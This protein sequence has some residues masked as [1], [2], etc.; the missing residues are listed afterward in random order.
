MNQESPVGVGMSPAAR[1]SRTPVLIALV[2]IVSSLLSA[3]AIN[4]VPAIRAFAF[5][6][7]AWVQAGWALYFFLMPLG[8][9]LVMVGLVGTAACFTAKYSKFHRAIAWSMAG[10]MLLI[11]VVGC[12]GLFLMS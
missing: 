1:S 6:E 5:N 11:A 12:L 3:V 2:P 9:G 8:A 4:S 7:E 10:L